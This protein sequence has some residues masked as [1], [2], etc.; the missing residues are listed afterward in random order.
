MIKTLLLVLI[1]LFPLGQLARFQL[2]NN[3]SFTVND[4][5]IGVVFLVWVIQI[6]LLRI[7]IL[8][9]QKS[10]LIFVGV[11]LGSLLLNSLWLNQSQLLISF[12]YLLRWVA[13]ASVYFMIS[14]QSQHSKKQ[15]LLAMGIS[16]FITVLIGYIQYFYY[17]NLRNLYYLG[18]DDHLYRLFSSFLDPN[19]AG[20][21][22]ALLFLF[23]AAFALYFFEKKQ[24]NEAIFLGI[25]SVITLLALFLTYSRSAFITLIISTTVFFLLKG[26]KKFI[27][28]VF[29]AF[30][31][32]VA[33]ISKNFY[34]ENINLFRMASSEARIESAKSALVIIQ[35]NPLIGVGFNAYRYAQIRY[36]YRISVESHADAGT[37]NS[38]LF[39]LATTG[40]VGLIAY[41]Y[42]WYTIT[43]KTYSAYRTQQNNTLK[44]TLSALILASLAGLFV[45][46]LFIN[47]LFYP[48]L[49]EWMWILAALL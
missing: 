3:I 48:L 27:V 25:F 39:V 7:N 38:F 1:Y 14:G 29:V 11:G 42:I 13:Y 16:G 6:V 26:Q 15:L 34:I 31:I 21:Y 20:A 36:G 8:K 18:W 40:I 28:V 22:F 44:Q 12:S 33:L 49:M 19:F 2:P 9:Q 46:S 41:L 37:D 4:I 5:L 23:V 24:K 32:F 47:S 17:P 45:D 35:K 10:I 30:L 43:K